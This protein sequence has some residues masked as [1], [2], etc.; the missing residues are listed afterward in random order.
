MH[1]ILFL[2]TQILTS[3]FLFSNLYV[4]FKSICLSVSLRFS[5]D[6][7]LF[8]L[9]RNAHRITPGFLFVEEI[10]VRALIFQDG[11]KD[12]KHIAGLLFV[13]HKFVDGLGIVRTGHVL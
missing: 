9:A 7:R 12:F 5:I 13:L 11:L 6:S 4:S 8:L 3:L 1:G 10:D 2:F